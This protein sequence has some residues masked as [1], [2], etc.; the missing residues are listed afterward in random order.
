MTAKNFLGM[1]SHPTDE[2]AQ[3]TCTKKELTRVRDIYDRA[4]TEG[5]TVNE[6]T[7]IFEWVIDMREIEDS[8]ILDKPNLV[9]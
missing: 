3:H 1:P 7:E 8:I 4:T 2:Y 9:G 5:I 6:C